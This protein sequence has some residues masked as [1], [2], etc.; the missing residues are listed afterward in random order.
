[1][2][3]NIKF[4]DKIKEIE[5]LK[6]DKEKLNKQIKEVNKNIYYLFIFYIVY[7]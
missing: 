1:M 6:I 7:K 3:V 2:E 4:N 5:K